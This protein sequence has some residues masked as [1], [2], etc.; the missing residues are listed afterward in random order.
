MELHVMQGLLQPPYLSSHRV[1]TDSDLQDTSAILT[2]G[3]K[4]G[5]TAQLGVWFQLAG[6]VSEHTQS[7]PWVL[8]IEGIHRP[9]DPNEKCD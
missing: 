8:C 2:D 7:C 4:V 1:P 5:L 3:W 6:R 9:Q